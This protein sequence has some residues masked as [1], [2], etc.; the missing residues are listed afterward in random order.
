MDGKG[1]NSVGLTAGS[2]TVLEKGIQRLNTRIGNGFDNLIRNVEKRKNT[3]VSNDWSKHICRFL[4]VATLFVILAF[5]FVFPA[6]QHRLHPLQHYHSSLNIFNSNPAGNGNGK[7]FIDKWWE[8]GRDYRKFA[9]F[10][11]EI[12][13]FCKEEVARNQAEFTYQ[14]NV[15]QGRKK[16]VFVVHHKTGTHLLRNIENE[17][18]RLAGMNMLPLGGCYGRNLHSW[19]VWAR[20]MEFWC[21]GVGTQYPFAVKG[22]RMVNLARH[23]RNMLI[24][25][26]IYQKALQDARLHFKDTVKDKDNKFYKGLKSNNTLMAWEGTMEIM[27]PV[28]DDMLKHMRMTVGDQGVLTVEME[29]HFYKDFDATVKNI[30][31]HLLQDKVSPEEMCKLRLQASFQDTQRFGAEVDDSHKSTHIASTDKKAIA[32]QELAEL[33]NCEDTKCKKFKD[34]YNEWVSSYEELTKLLW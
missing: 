25:Q 23:P 14:G 34:K 12:K 11:G 26:H 19:T 31:Y 7:S 21:K 18:L 22:N 27:S 1:E 13:Q 2:M 15:T 28:I 29:Q 9:E 6:E 17:L 3:P 4:F 30:F 33:L 24:S 10:G 32:K 8:S 5:F 20:R 16:L